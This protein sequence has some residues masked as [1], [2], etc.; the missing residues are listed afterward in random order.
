MILVTKLILILI[1]SFINKYIEIFNY[2]L[3]YSDI[4]INIHINILS[5]VIQNI[6]NAI[7]K[8]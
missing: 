1:Y 8:I 4:N 2:L 7:T 5:Y 3:E 6:N